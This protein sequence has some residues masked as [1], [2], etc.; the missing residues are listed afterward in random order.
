MSQRL[1][2]LSRKCVVHKNTL[3]QQIGHLQQ[4]TLHIHTTR[5]HGVVLAVQDCLLCKT[6]LTIITLANRATGNVTSDPKHTVL[7]NK[8]HYLTEDNE[9]H[10]MLQERSN[11]CY[12]CCQYCLANA[13]QALRVD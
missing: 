8:F 6:G 1:Q 10:K 9:C 11:R 12:I 4:P 2:D 7:P 3:P 5:T 13:R